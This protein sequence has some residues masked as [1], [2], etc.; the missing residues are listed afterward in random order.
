M[1]PPFSIQLD[2]DIE[3]IVQGRFMTLNNSSEIHMSFI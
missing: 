3:V 2:P 1:Q